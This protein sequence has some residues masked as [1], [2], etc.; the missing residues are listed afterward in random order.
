MA[1]IAATVNY[2]GLLTTQPASFLIPSTAT[3]AGCDAYVFIGSNDRTVIPAPT[4][5]TALPPVTTSTTAQ[6]MSRFVKRLVASDLGTTV[7]FPYTGGAAVRTSG[8]MVI[9][10]D[11]QS[12]SVTAVTAPSTTATTTFA[13]PSVVAPSAGTLLIAF[14]NARYVQ[15]TAAGLETPA[16]WNEICDVSTTNST[17][18]KAGAWVAWKFAAPPNPIAASVTVTNA[19]T[20]A[21]FGGMTI[22]ITPLPRVYVRRGGLLVPLQ[23]IRRSSEIVR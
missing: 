16:T 8:S 13:I 12:P 3:L 21:F 15:G 7:T 9:V 5:W 2:A 1:S 17:G 14:V 23:S 11:G 19:A 20:T 4:G 22:G 6:G 10:K 18:N